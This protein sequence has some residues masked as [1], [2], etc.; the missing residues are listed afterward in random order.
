MPT[1]VKLQQEISSKWSNIH[2]IDILKESDL[3]IQFTREIETVG[4]SSSILS[5][6]LQKRLL[7]SHLTQKHYFHVNLPVHS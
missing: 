6:D 5:S 4:K 1:W 2:L 3:R 7:L